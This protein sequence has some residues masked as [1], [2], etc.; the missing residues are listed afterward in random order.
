MTKILIIGAGHG[1][2]R[3]VKLMKDVGIPNAQYIL[4]GRDSLNY[5]YDRFAEI[6]YYDLYFLNDID[7]LPA[8]SGPS[9]FKELAENIKDTISQII[10]YHLNLDDSE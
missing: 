8:G 6:P 5:D 3:A 7:G 4:F 2:M 10:D 9:C 1:G